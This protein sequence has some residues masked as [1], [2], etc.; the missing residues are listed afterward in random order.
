[1]MN[2]I[3][4]I[5]ALLYVLSLN[6]VLLSG[7]KVYT[8]YNIF[9]IVFFLYFFSFVLFFTFGINFAYKFFDTSANNIAKSVSVSF[10]YYIVFFSALF[11]LTYQKVINFTYS[12]PQYSIIWL[13]FYAFITN[14]LFLYVYSRGAFSYS[15]HQESLGAT[16]TTTYLILNYTLIYLF[17]MVLSTFPKLGIFAKSLTIVLTVEYFSM[18]LLM[19]NR[20]ETLFILLIIFSNYIVTHTVTWRFFAISFVAGLLL[21]T[22]GIFREMQNMTYLELARVMSGGVEF[23]LPSQTL[24]YVISHKN[25]AP[26]LFFSPFTTF[27]P[28][29]I[30]PGKLESIGYYV[31]G[32]FDKYFT[33]YTIGY[34]CTPVTEAYVVFSN[35]FLLNI[36]VAMFFVF[37]FS[38]LRNS[39]LLL[40]GMCFEYVRGEL[41]NIMVL[42]IYFTIT[43]T[44]VT[45]VESF[46]NYFK[47]SIR[48]ENQKMA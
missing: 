27:I 8:I 33:G 35:F 12:P 42:I 2:I 48:L 23:A 43:Y 32:M 29:A 38:K 39:Y 31:N 17:A 9:A 6:R 36:P 3:L 20:K 1:M 4:P 41:L 30:L 18:H 47:R 45:L 44:I 34:A 15:T 11:F 7:R 5:L 22:V 24:L 16:Y 21:F 13:I 14:G 26:E 25:F 40:L 37:L 10:V 19:G 46:A 28:S